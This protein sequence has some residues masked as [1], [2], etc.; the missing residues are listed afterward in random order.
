MK[1]KENDYLEDWLGLEKPEDVIEFELPI[2]DPHHHLWDIR[3]PTNEPHK[4]FLQK[5]Y[6]IDE[7]SNDILDSGHNIT[8]TV[9]AQCHAFYREDGPEHMRCIGEVDFANGIAAMSRS[10]LYG[11]SKICSG[12]FGAANLHLGN[13][14]EIVLQALKAASPNLKG[15]R[16]YDTNFNNQFHKGFK[17]LE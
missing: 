13:D 4:I 12:I 7:Y 9:F 17:L 3:K 10:G 5:V 16:T 15:I 8:Q 11:K 6:L 1:I 14:V 2:V